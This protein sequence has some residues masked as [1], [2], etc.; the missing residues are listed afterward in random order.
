MILALFLAA[1]VSAQAASP[2]ALEMVKKADENI[3]GKTFQATVQME[4]KKEEGSRGLKFKVWNQGKEKALIKVM[5]PAKDR[6]TGNLRIGFNLWQYL[7]NVERVI[8]IPPSMMLQNWMGSDFSNDDL[9]KSSAL[10]R[11][12]TPEIAGH[13]KLG[14]VETVKILCKPKPDAPVVWDKVVVWLTEKDYVPVRH[15]FYSEK[16][17][18]LRRME[19]SEIRAFGRHKIATVLK[20]TS[21]K[22]NSSTTIRYSDVVFDQAIPEK[23]FTQENQRRPL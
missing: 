2:G 6:N 12:Y 19:G 18:I 16:G 7:P 9:V 8:K 3:F 10:S 5:E 11:D 1:A 15:E 4:I 20:M 17:E 21:L 13:E 14:A 22:K 23:V